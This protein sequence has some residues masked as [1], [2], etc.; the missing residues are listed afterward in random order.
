MS[1]NTMKTGIDQGKLS[2]TYSLRIPRK[3]KISMEE[4]LNVDAKHRLNNEVRLLIAKHCHESK[5]NPDEYLS[6]D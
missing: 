5:F 3:L 6:E 4:Y 2:E 1:D